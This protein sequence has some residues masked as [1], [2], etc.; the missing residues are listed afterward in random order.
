M[1]RE[2][3][4][5]KPAACPTCAREL[6]GGFYADGSRGIRAGDFVVC[7]GCGNI[8]V[9]DTDMQP[10]VSVDSDFQNTTPEA[11]EK[12]RIAQDVV[13]RRIARQ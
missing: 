11:L 4:T 1:K 8:L 12:L 6:S 5:F 13:R 10:V 7:P 2:R 9:L 3:V